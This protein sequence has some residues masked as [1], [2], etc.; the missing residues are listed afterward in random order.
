MK[1]LEV[2]KISEEIFERIRKSREDSKLRENSTFH[3]NQNSFTKFVYLRKSNSNRFKKV[4][5]KKK[6]ESSTFES[7][8]FRGSSKF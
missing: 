7:Q 8:N 3:K 6:F 1:K 5:S 2:E 4:I